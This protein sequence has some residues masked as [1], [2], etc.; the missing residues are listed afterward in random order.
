LDITLDTKLQLTIV[1]IS[2]IK[3]NTYNIRK[4]IIQTNKKNIISE[5][6]NGTRFKTNYIYIMKHTYMLIIQSIFVLLLAKAVGN[7]PV[8]YR[9][10]LLSLNTTLGEE[11]T[12][13]PTN[14]SFGS[15]TPSVF[16]TMESNVSLII[17][18]TGCRTWIEETKEWTSSGCTVC[19]LF[20]H[21]FQFVRLLLNF[22]TIAL[23]YKINALYVLRVNP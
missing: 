23:N 5:K 12:Q 16:E 21:V 22:D 3:N 20:M 4:M 15:T 10:K 18:T 19:L 9:R 2:E 7:I 11:T 14:E 1:I 6:L 8:G 17:M 13:N